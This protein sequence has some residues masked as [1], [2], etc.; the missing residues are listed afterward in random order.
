MCGWL[1]FWT[2]ACVQSEA[3][4]KEKRRW[5]FCMYQTKWTC[6]LF[7]S[8]WNRSLQKY[9]W[10]QA[11]NTCKFS[12]RK[13]RNCLRSQHHIREKR[14][15]RART[16]QYT[17]PRHLGGGFRPCLTTNLL[18]CRMW[19]YLTLP[20]IQFF[21]TCSKVPRIL[22]WHGLK[23]YPPMVACRNVWDVRIYIVFL[24]SLRIS[25]LVEFLSSRDIFCF[26]PKNV[27][28]TFL[29]SNRTLSGHLVG[30]KTFAWG[31][32]LGSERCVAIHRAVRATIRSARR[33]VISAKQF[34]A[35]LETGKCM[36]MHFSSLK[37]ECEKNWGS[38][39]D[40]VGAWMFFR[41]W[42]RFGLQ[43][44]SLPGGWGQNARD[45]K[46]K[47][48]WNG[49]KV[50]SSCRP[51]IIYYCRHRQYIDSFRLHYILASSFSLCSS[52]S[53]FSS[54]TSLQL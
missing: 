50:P 42:T 47:N 38:F 53:S 44:T 37:M 31:K 5:P 54:F 33:E 8:K 10:K 40:G 14:G 24:S 20:R 22:G 3:R 27:T 1:K 32:P 19:P 7:A 2:V 23:G 35:E 9:A 25:P 28:T 29:S 4:G 43:Y 12:S 41:C 13:I 26:Q 16:G 45:N 46:A 11:A 15:N 34:E 36:E 49:R 52:S 6:T 39:S 18:L 17:L 51:T 30:S 21:D 48:L